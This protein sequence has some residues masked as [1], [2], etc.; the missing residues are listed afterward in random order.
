MLIPFPPQK[1]YSIAKPN[2]FE[3]LQTRERH[4]RM[5]GE[6]PWLLLDFT[7]LVFEILGTLMTNPYF[8]Y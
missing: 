6:D 4:H 7:E 8:N 5:N 3:I 1:T 2:L